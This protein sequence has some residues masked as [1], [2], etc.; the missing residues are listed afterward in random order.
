MTF[1]EHWSRAGRFNMAGLVLVIVWAPLSIQGRNECGAFVLG[2]AA[3][4]VG[5]GVWHLVSAVRMGARE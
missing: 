4:F 5:L 2:A 1:E 3:V